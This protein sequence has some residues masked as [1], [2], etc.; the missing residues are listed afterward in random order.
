M[1]MD[2]KEISTLFAEGIERKESEINLFGMRSLE[3][4][5]KRDYYEQLT[6]F[7]KLDLRYYRLAQAYYSGEFDKLDDGLNEDL[8]LMTSIDISPKLYACYLRELCKDDRI[9][10]KMTREILV[11][12][13]HSIR[14]SLGLK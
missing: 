5:S 4:P 12:L 8:L 13:K 14:E 1:K 7:V 9:N 6:E 2:R 11:N 3:T 10:E